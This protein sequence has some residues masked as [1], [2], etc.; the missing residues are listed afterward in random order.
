MPHLVHA[1]NTSFANAQNIVA[2][3]TPF[4]YTLASSTE[5]RFYVFQSVSG[6]SY[7]V[8]VVASPTEVTTPADSGILVFRQDQT[9]LIVGSDDTLQEPLTGHN[10][11]G[12]GLSRAC[13]IAPA[14]EETYVVVHSFHSVAV[15]FSGRV[16]ET[17]LFSNWFFLGGDYGAFTILRNTTSSNL[18]YTI[19][20]RNGAGAIVATQSAALAGHAGTF[21]NAGAF[22][23]AVSAVSGTIEVAHTGSPDALVAST[24]VLS[25]TT[26]LSFDAPFTKRQP[27]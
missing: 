21:V 11:S 3:Q 15:A 8:E 5:D 14:T 12:F 26:G 19:N 27:W 17:T 18:N 6:R 2:G 25:G 10:S 23:A 1:Q 20:W 9:T 24:T 7:C 16:V 4:L 22:P 13:W